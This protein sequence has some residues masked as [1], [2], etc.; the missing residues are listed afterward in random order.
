MTEVTEIR[1]LARELPRPC[2]RGLLTPHP[3][4]IPLHHLQQSP[5]PNSPGVAP[6]RLTLQREQL[7]VGGAIG[8]AMA[9]DFYGS[10]FLADLCAVGLP[11]LPA[12]LARRPGGLSAQ[13]LPRVPPGEG[14]GRHPASPLQKKISQATT[15]HRDQRGGKSM[16]HSSAEPASKPASQPGSR[17]SPS[18]S[19]PPR[20]HYWPHDLGQSPYP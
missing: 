15:F 16:P 17:S 18:P 6:F 7:R 20:P 11:E 2:S 9:W 19:T 5:L 10:L 4:L 8:L 3:H 12:T 1:R 13:P 14:G